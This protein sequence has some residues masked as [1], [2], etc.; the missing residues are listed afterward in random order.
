M[1]TLGAAIAGFSGQSISV[2][3]RPQPSRFFVAANSRHLWA[4]FVGQSSFH[5][6]TWGFSSCLQQKRLPPWRRSKRLLPWRQSQRSY[7]AFLH[8]AGWALRSS[9][10][11]CGIEM[12]PENR[13]FGCHGRREKAP[14]KWTRQKALN[15]GA[16]SCPLSKLRSAHLETVK[17]LPPYW[18]SRTPR[19]GTA[20]ARRFLDEP[21]RLSNRATPERP[22]RRS[23][24][25]GLAPLEA[26]TRNQ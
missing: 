19:I 10:I 21:S 17:P 11:D 22:A 4:K 5:R 7:V 15:Q 23:R 20:V 6:T 8:S 16:Q 2:A 1:W 3:A 26:R 18:N 25:Q 12:A 9:A 14:G 13:G 24:P